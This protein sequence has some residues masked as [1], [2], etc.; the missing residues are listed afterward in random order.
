MSHDSRP[1]TYAHIEQ[2][3][4]L[5]LQVIDDLLK[6]AHEHDKSKLVEPERAVF[7]RISP[8]MDKL[9][10]GSAEYE[11]IRTSQGE[12]MRHHYRLNRHHPE[13]HEQGIDGMNLLD[14][15]EM[16]ADWKAATQRHANGGL[17]R[18]INVNRERYGYGEVMER[19]LRNTARDLGW[20]E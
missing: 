12:G 19:L 11:A 17:D 5:L 10:Y 13:H 1:D 16:L 8:N 18:S 3:R 6:R 9:T 2:V 20:L 4:A 14:L 15:I 7:D